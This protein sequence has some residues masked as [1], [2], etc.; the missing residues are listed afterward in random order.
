LTHVPLKPL[1]GQ[2]LGPPP[3]Q[4]QQQQQMLLLRGVQSLLRR[5]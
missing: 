3:A 5:L 2:L 1:Q 4:Q